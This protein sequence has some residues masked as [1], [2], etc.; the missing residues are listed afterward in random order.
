MV[1]I[2]KKPVLSKKPPSKDKGTTRIGKPALASSHL[3]ASTSTKKQTGLPV[4]AHTTIKLVNTAQ[5]EARMGTMFSK[6]GPSNGKAKETFDDIRHPT[7]AIHAQMQARV[8][9][10]M[11]QARQDD[12]AIASE[13]IELPDINSEYVSVSTSARYTK[14]L[15][16][17][18]PDTP[19]QKTRI[20]PKRSINQIGPNLL[21]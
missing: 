2:E 11:L 21:S 17:F 14:S 12:P 6:P 9:E 4:P 10:K 19:T 16:S 3:G 8:E 13:A 7:L 5:T 18:P 20:A 1:E 15:H